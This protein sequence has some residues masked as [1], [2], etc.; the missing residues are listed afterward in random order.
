[1][2]THEH[3]HVHRLYPKYLKNILRKFNLTRR[4]DSF[5]LH[6]TG[7]RWISILRYV[8]YALHR[9][10]DGGREPLFSIVPVPVP[11]SVYEPLQE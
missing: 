6:G 3:C 7:K 4:Y 11:C 8:L 10:T 2:R 1:M 5:T 9:D